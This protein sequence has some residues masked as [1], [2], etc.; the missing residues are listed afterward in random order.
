MA[1]SQSRRTPTPAFES[2]YRHG[3]LRVAVCTPR[4]EVASPE[5]NA[6]Q[7]LSLVR[8]AAEERAALAL[9]PELGLSAYS[10]EDLFQQDALLDAS[11]A[12]ARAIVADASR[13][14]STVVIVGLPLRLDGRLFNCAVVLQRGRV[15]GVVPKSY[16]PELP[17]VLREAAVCPAAQA[18]SGTVR[19]L[20]A[21]VPFGSQLLFA[22]RNLAGCVLH[23][24]ICEDVWV[25]LPPSTFAALAGATVLANLSASDITVGKADY[26]R[27]ICAA[28]SAQM[29]R[30]LSLLGRGSRRVDDRPRVGRPRTDL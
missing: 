2:I 13:D 19:L 22:A 26:R 9:F 8:Q 23:V 20:G 16:L 12:G 7:T 11:L 10:N 30:G 25:P 15:L 1:A 3:F 29:R 21:D 6:R 18:I 24:E 14:L 17:R 4:V 28:Q 5:F 27:L